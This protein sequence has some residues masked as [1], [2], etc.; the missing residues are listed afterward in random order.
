MQELLKRKDVLLKSIKEGQKLIFKG[1]YSR[2]LYTFNKQAHDY[3]VE[4]DDFAWLQE[5]AKKDQQ[6]KVIS[7][8]LEKVTELEER[9]TG[10]VRTNYF[11]KEHFIN[12]DGRSVD[13]DI[14][15]HGGASAAGFRG[16][17]ASAS[18]Q[19]FRGSYVPKEKGQTSALMKKLAGGAGKK[20]M[21]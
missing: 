17:N 15:S 1:C 19:G 4:K 2:P 11:N 18:G 8:L 16:T 21:F 9:V 3:N 20:V 7:R 6:K 5:G 13:F 14:Q 12:D 10:D